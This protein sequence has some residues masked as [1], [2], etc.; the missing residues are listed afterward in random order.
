MLSDEQFGFSKGRSCVTQLLVTINDWLDSLDGGDPV[1]AI[2]LDLRKAFDTVSH[3][4]LILKLSKYGVS[5]SLLR[6]ITDF[7]TGRT[8]YVNI[9]GNCST[10]ND[11]T[12][13][14]PQGSVLGP[15][16][17][18]YFINDLPETVKCKVKVFADDTKAYCSVDK[19]ENSK[20]FVQKC[21]DDLVDWSKRWKMEFNSLKCKVM[22]LGKDNPLHEYTIENGNERNTLETTVA[23]KD[24]GVIVD[25]DL[26]FD[27][28]ITSTVNKCRRISGL[29][30]RTMSNNSRDVMVPLF[31]A[32]IRPILE[33]GNAVWCPSLRK[34]CDL[35]ES[36]Q[37]Q[38]TKKIIG[39]SHLDYKNRLMQ[40]GL[41]SLE[42]RRFRGDLIEVYKMMNGLYDPIVVNNL[43]SISNSD[44]TRG[45]NKKLVKK[46]TNTNTA[47]HF[48]SNR[49]VNSWNEL[50]SQA[51]N[52]S[53][54]NV[55]K[56]FIDDIYFEY[57]FS[58]N[59]DL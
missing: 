4:R 50:P 54:I 16:L 51:V 2:Y 43:F 32:L 6:W 49:V 5:G 41:P 59:L 15:T 12:S 58:T 39:L 1:D 56:N 7:L 44:R 19:D 53:S 9:N 22:H 46:R 36:V 23:E 45:H 18:I 14:V 30:V 38:F 21:V 24:L 35:L 8:Q 33:Y 25:P 40:L 48:F 52:A 29:I 37:R 31:K 28:H 42:Y 34:H 47:L 57:Q 55:F 27:K 26:N 3:R 10:T 11:V 17:F 13:G 20:V